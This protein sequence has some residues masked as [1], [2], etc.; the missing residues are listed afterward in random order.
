[1]ITV[2]ISFFSLEERSRSNSTVC[3]TRSIGARRAMREYF[4]WHQCMR[5]LD[6]YLEAKHGRTQQDPLGHSWS[7]RYDAEWMTPSPHSPQA[8]ALLA[9]PPSLPPLWKSH[10]S[11]SPPIAKKETAIFMYWYVLVSPTI[12]KHNATIHSDYSPSLC[13]N[14]EWKVERMWL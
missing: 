8:A 11:D 14:T 4:H 2:C 13:G 6:L 5:H 7:G 12:G 9:P 10:F 1:M 3:Q